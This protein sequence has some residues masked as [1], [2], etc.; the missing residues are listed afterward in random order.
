VTANR[1]N[2]YY[3][4][5]VVNFTARFDE[6]LLRR[7]ANPPPLAS[8]LDD[9]PTVPTRR[10]RSRP[11]PFRKTA[12]PDV[13]SDEGR[14]TFIMNRQPKSCSVEF[15]SVRQAATFDIK[16][17]FAD[18]PIDPRTLRAMAAEIHFGTVPAQDYARGVQDRV[19]ANRRTSLLRTR[20]DDGSPNESTLMMVGVVDEADIDFSSSGAEIS[21]RGRDLRGMLLDSPIDPRFV[22]KLPMDLPIN[23]IVEAIIFHHP[24]S[25]HLRVRAFPSDWANGVIPG[26]LPQQLVPRHR[27]GARGRRA[28]SPAHAGGGG[29]MS[30]WDLIVKLCFFVGAVPVF[31]GRT[32][33]IKPV[34]TLFEQ[35]GIARGEGRRAANDRE[36][37]PFDPDEPRLMDGSTPYTFRRMVYG[38]DIEKLTFNRKFAG[39]QKPKV[40]RCVSADPTGGQD[41]RVVEAR[42]PLVPPRRLS[43]PTP[44]ATRGQVRDPRAQQAHANAARNVAAP[45]AG[46]DQAEIITV[47]VYGITDVERLTAI[48]RGLYEEIGR[49]EIGG[50]VDTK[51]LASFGGSNEDPDLLRIRPGDAIEFFIDQAAN[52]VGTIS[53]IT[54][55]TND[56]YRMPYE[57]LVQ[58]IQRRVGDPN[59]AAAIAAAQRGAVNQLQ[60]VFRASS[61]SLGWSQSG[62]SVGIDFQNYFVVRYDVG[63][64]QS[65]N[66][67]TVTQLVVPDRPRT[68]GR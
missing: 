68:N 29:D 9:V 45:G 20:N 4:S 38:R 40:V 3:P 23:E 5:C 56:F 48:A 15:P 14:E 33:T 67:T 13:V 55:T 53:G 62:F 36:A 21:I 27:R 63:G 50:H 18:M 10:S 65:T 31:L 61:V 30:Y 25:S 47:P 1:N 26:C 57:Q 11:D 22:N 6:A 51:N 24:M 49:N 43:S 39:N 28:G 2:V 17:D 41:T 60:R 59:L 32:L 19:P 8:T 7:V 34:R 12:R 52:P 35:T 54:S 16:F 42:W 46:E 44:A 64:N 37:T 58:E 66:G